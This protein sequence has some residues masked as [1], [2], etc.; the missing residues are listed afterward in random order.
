MYILHL[1]KENTLMNIDKKSVM[2]EIYFQRARV[3]TKEQLLAYNKQ[4]NISKYIKSKD[5]EIIVEEIRN[6]IS[7]ISYKLPLYDEYTHNMYL[8]NREDVYDRV[9]YEYY[10]FPE[11][12]LIQVLNTKY[13]MLIK[14]PD[15]KEKIY[16]YQSDINVNKEMYRI[17]QAARNNVG[18]LQDG[19]SVKIEELY[20]R[21]IRKLRLMLDFLGQY[22]MKIL[23]ETYV[24]VFY[25]YSKVGKNITVCIRPSFLPYLKHLTPYYNQNEL[26]KMGLNMGII[27]ESDINN[28]QKIDLLCSDVSKNDISS[29][30]ILKH[31][32]HIIK[33]NK[34]GIMQYY[35]L[36]GSY[37][38]NQY[39][40]NFNKSSFKNKVLEEK[41]FS[42][43]N[44]INTAPSFD[45]PYTLY[46]FVNDDYYLKHLKKGDMYKVPNF[47][48]TT[49]D[50]F[51]RP[52]DYQFGFILIKIK[53]P[54]KKEGV[55]LCIET[56]SNFPKEQEI[57]LS[58]LSVLRLDNKDENVPYYH[59]D[60][61]YELQIKTRYEFTYIGKG[62]ITFQNGLSVKNEQPYVDFMK[63]KLNH[64]T[65]LQDNINT[66]LEN[67]T[68]TL[69][70]C[71]VMIGKRTF[72]LI[73][74][75][76]DS[77]GAYR[78]FYASNTTNGFI[79]YTF[80][81][82]Y[83]GFTIEMGEDSDG[84]YMYVNYYYRYS[85]VP[86]ENYI[87]DSELVMFVSKVAYCFHINKVVIYCTYRSCD[88]QQFN[89]YDGAQIYYDGGIYCE[90]FYEYLSLN[91]KKYN[92][93]GITC[94]FEYKM[95][96]ELKNIDPLKILRKSD[97]DELYQIYI[98]K[99]TKD[100]PDKLNIADFY[101]WLVHNHCKF[102][103]YL[104][105][106]IKRIYKHNNPFKLDYYI[107]DVNM[108]MTTY[109]IIDDNDIIPSESTI[110]IKLP[111]NEYR[112]I[113]DQ[114]KP[115][116]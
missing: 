99:Y 68:D 98:K 37:F 72:V 56:V 87:N 111:K 7:K 61:K 59:V 93:N 50:P 53:I 6:N 75:Y 30:I 41:A 17:L 54:A 94:G 18:Y 48:S 22:N 11:E 64:K 49:R 43:W 28:Q 45:K 1:V 89:T 5:P 88:F 62:P 116:Y 25:Y 73:S 46:R 38:L 66:F 92:F 86:K 21:E 24:K 71:S 58:P 9:V 60:E 108:Y 80:I 39:L 115:R 105:D 97:R 42:I 103:N 13:Q 102:A 95:L 47:L 101:I 110:K 44:L 77:T 84:K 79:F 109:K 70:Q 96:D 40:I 65:T 27:K 16:G 67:Y 107:L 8:I 100:Y 2:D 104:V 85:T 52:S 33:N 112:I 57:I 32:K 29:K 19:G 51:Y 10:R 15:K 55:A 4:D 81:G 69:L 63:I 90:D 91:N 76:F 113:H 31:H 34:I 78:N 23:K 26:I 12:E 20:E 82:D 14:N 74:E 114:S 83:I 106:K 36:Q 3:P 35:T